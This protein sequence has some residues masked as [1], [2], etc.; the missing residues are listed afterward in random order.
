MAAAV[1]M[2]MCSTKISYRFNWNEIFSHGL[3]E[4]APPPSA[5]DIR[6]GA[7][8]SSIINIIALYKYYCAVI[9]IIIV[10]NNK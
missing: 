1:V 3:R 10:K 7:F 6:R 2:F 9:I 8:F 4:P 5:L